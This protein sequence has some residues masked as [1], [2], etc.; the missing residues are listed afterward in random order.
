[1]T[2]PDAPF[3]T[4]A[5]AA[6]GDFLGV[7]QKAF[8]EGAEAVVC[9]NV[10]G[11]LSGTLKAADLVAALHDSMEVFIS[12]AIDGEVIGPEFLIETLRKI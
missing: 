3:P 6:P 5:A 10:S 1:M 11:S 8:D 4:T 2:A 9:V 7:F 12:S